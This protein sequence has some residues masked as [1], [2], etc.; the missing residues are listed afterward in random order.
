M[1]A[2]RDLGSHMALAY[3]VGAGVVAMFAYVTASWL[4]TLR[5]PYW[6]PIAAVIVLYP[7]RE[8]TVKAGVQRLFGTAIGSVVGWASAAWWRENV[9]LYGTAIVVA[10]AVCHL[11]RLP[12]AARLCAVTVS[13]ITIIPHRESA[14]AVALERFITVSYGVGCALAYMAAVD[15]VRRLGKARS[16]RDRGTQ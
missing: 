11:L 1:P 8:A 10:V 3:G 16:E 7:D 6:A 5:E 9:L 14:G 15:A 2:I 12:D 4:P 13:V